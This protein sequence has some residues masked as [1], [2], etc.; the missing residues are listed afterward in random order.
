MLWK[1]GELIMFAPFDPLSTE[2]KAHLS[3]SKTTT[4]PP[5]KAS[6]SP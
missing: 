1:I 3:L 2:N 5:F 6:I 4:L